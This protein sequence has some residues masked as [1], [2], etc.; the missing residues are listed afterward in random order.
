[1]LCPHDQLGNVGTSDESFVR[2]KQLNDVLANV[3]Q[4]FESLDS[5]LVGKLQADSRKLSGYIT[6]KIEL[7][8]K[9]LAEELTRQ[10]RSENERVKKEELSLKIQVEDQN[11]NESFNKLNKYSQ[12]ELINVQTSVESDLGRVEGRVDAHVTETRKQINSI[13]EEASVRTKA[14]MTDIVDHRSQTEA[15]INAVR[16]EIVYVKE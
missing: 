2:P 7:A 8:N 15:Y 14:L 5:K 13:S 1:V 10:F 4:R 6:S 11:L 12:I 3:M 9:K 16:Q